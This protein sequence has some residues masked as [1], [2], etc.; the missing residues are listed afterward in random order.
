MFRHP[1]ARLQLLSTTVI[2]T[3]MKG[4][5]FVLL[6]AV[7]AAARADWSNSCIDEE[8]LEQNVVSAAQ[9]GHHLCA[10]IVATV[11][12]QVEQQQV[13]EYFLYR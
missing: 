11:R 3:K 8:C 9:L 10:T 12:L 13:C 6:A 5:S 1:Q 7:L 2:C 4:I